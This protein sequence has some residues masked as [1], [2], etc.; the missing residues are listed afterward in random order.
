MYY[1]DILSIKIDIHLF[2]FPLL[3]YRESCCWSI[4]L[5]IRSSMRRWFRN[6]GISPK[7][8]LPAIVMQI[9]CN[10]DK[11]Y[12]WSL[13]YLWFHFFSFKSHKKYL[14]NNISET[15]SALKYL[16][17]LYADHYIIVNQKWSHWTF[18]ALANVDGEA[19]IILC[20]ISTSWNTSSKL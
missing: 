4:H 10:V 11:K 3:Q 7:T 12:I 2:R 6:S 14:L 5:R 16:V 9:K 8:Y 13:K 15:R 18:K 17:C 1:I 19:A 20:K